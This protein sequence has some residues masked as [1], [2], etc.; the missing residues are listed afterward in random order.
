MCVCVLCCDVVWC[1]YGC[2]CVRVRVCACT[3]V[4]SRVSCALASSPQQPVTP[5]KATEVDPSLGWFNWI[6]PE[7]LTNKSISQQLLFPRATLKITKAPCRE[8]L[9]GA[10]QLKENNKR[11]T[12][13]RVLLCRCLQ[14][15]VMTGKSARS[16]RHNCKLD[17]IPNT[18]HNR[19][20][21]SLLEFRE[22]Q[23]CTHTNSYSG[24]CNM[25]FVRAT[26]RVHARCFVFSPTTHLWKI[27]SSSP[28]EHLKI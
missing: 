28:R 17:E 13:C 10:P 14:L 15:P 21:Y 5:I 19:F 27:R 4:C 3:Y 23:F 26:K 2:G 11:R 24:C 16:S 6:Y 1:G 8:I 9:P 18:K 20:N 25:R 22:N 12:K 7:I